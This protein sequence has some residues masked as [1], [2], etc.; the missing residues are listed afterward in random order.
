MAFLDQIPKGLKM[1]WVGD[2]IFC[3]EKKLHESETT[4]QG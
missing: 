3:R 1:T 4:V 2:H